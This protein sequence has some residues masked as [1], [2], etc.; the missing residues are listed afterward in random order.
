MTV[1]NWPEKLPKP[2][3]QG[4]GIEPM[5][6]VLRT[7]M[8]SGPARQRR[9]YTQTPTSIT[10]R[11]RFNEWQFAL[12]ESWFVNRAKVGAAWFNIT[13]LGGLGLTEHQARFLGEG[14]KPYRAAPA[15]GVGNIWIVTS[16][17][18]IRERPVL[19]SEALEVALV[20]D[21]PALIS[22]IKKF[23]SLV[24]VS[25]PGPSGWS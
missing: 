19:S 6:A 11:W 3:Y 18:E 1:E 14:K 25:M 20:E 23:N 15:R 21:V 22:A 24:S 10:V 9:R 16:N 4:F 5:D 8:E 13:L 12:F 7:E 2:T 17:L